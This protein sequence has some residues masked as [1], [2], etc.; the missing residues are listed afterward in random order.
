[1]RKVKRQKMD[2]SSGHNTW[3]SYSDMMSGMLL[4]FIL[5]MAVC[6]MQAQKN[7]TEK[8]AEQ[9]RASQ[10]QS[11]L[12][13]SQS[14]VQDQQSRLDEQE[15]ELTA[16]QLTLSEQAAALEALQAQLE[17]QQLSLNEKESELTASQAQVD[18]QSA[19][20][21]T[22]TQQLTDQQTK[23]NEQE[24]ELAASQTQLDAANNL[25]AQQ[26]AKIDQIIG[27]KAD[28]IQDLKN[29]FTAN[30][31]NVQLD[32]ETG[33]ILLDSSVLFDLNASVLTDEGKA[34][35]DQILPIYC[36]VLMSKDYADYVAEVI[37]DG[38]TDTTG[39]YISNLALSQSRAYAVGEYLYDVKNSFLDEEAGN[40][41]IAKLTANGKS[42]S[43]P[44]LNDD[45]SVNM[46]A[47]RRV[48]IKFRL[49]DE[50]M[51][52]ELQTIISDSKE[53]S[54]ATAQADTDAPAETAAG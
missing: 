43:N 24:S 2:D 29:E 30:Q 26:Q 42:S 28:L 22:Q 50:E 8:L 15:S 17:A 32:T 41:L 10:T 53:E 1:M 40:Q 31:I 4:L 21:A 27:V 48:E 51:L 9:A 37:V 20:L 19:Q 44:I 25:M 35:L 11:Q 54:A 33:A 39:D 45:G 13:A 14:T 49:K 52:S 38:Y 16:Q 5:I 34:A 7:Y 18:A 36:Q 46:D 12:E 3:R 23:L 6:L 47:S